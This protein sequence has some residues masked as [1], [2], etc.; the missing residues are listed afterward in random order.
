[1]ELND[2]LKEFIFRETGTKKKLT[3]DT[4]L[5]ADL[6]Y[7]GEDLKEILIKFFEEFQISY[8]IT[9]LRKFEAMESGFFLSTLKGIM[10]IL[11][12]KRDEDA[13]DISLRQ[14]QD[15]LYSKRWNG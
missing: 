5:G 8:N 14:L 10:N 4:F 13:N 2:L 6:G 3:S 15:A 9:D 7:D 1:M 11:R 12:G